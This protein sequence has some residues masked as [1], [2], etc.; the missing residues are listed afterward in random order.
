MRIEE[1]H[2]IKGYTSYVK[3]INEQLLIIILEIERDLSVSAQNSLWDRLIFANFVSTSWLWKTWR[4]ILAKEKRRNILKELQYDMY[5]LLA[6]K[7]C[8]GKCKTFLLKMSFIGT[9]TKN[10]FHI[11]SSALT[12]LWNR[13]LAQ[14]ETGLIIYGANYGLW[15]QEP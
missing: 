7:A 9:R 4:G 2:R 3:A 15:H 10:L 8:E 12:S 1:V 14:L 5:L 11:K 6:G 13:G